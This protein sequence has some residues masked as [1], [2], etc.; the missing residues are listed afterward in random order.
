LINLADDLL[1][2]LAAD[3]RFEQ[4]CLNAEVPAGIEL[5]ADR[6]QLHQTLL[7]LLQNGAESMPGGGELTLSAAVQEGRDDAGHVFS[8]VRLMV[9]DRGS[10]LD[11]ETSRHLFEPFWTTKPAGTGLGLATVYRIVE[12]HG[13]TIQAQPREGGGT[14]FTILLPIV[15]G[16][17]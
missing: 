13:G 3:A 16:I 17:A 6:A 12:A 5:F 15:E 9:A 14:V 7:N 4:I 1:T 2:L 8:L 10:G 11:D